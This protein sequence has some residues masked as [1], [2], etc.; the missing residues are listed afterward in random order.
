MAKILV[1]DDDAAILDM[2]GYFL[3]KDVHFVTKV[4]N[5]LDIIME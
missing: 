5:P 4:G 3:S 2:I 1:V